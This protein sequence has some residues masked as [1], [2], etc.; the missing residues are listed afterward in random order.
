METI[1]NLDDTRK[2]QIFKKQIISDTEVEGLTT[3]NRLVVLNISIYKKDKDYHFTFQLT[4]LYNFI[5]N[6]IGYQEINIIGIHENEKIEFD[7]FHPIPQEHCILDNEKHKN[8]NQ[9]SYCHPDK[10]KKN[11]K[12]LSIYEDNFNQNEQKDFFKE[13]EEEKKRHEEHIKYKC[14]DK[15]GFS[16]STCES[17]SFEK[18]LYGVWDK[19]CEKNTD[20][21]F[22]KSNR[23]YDNERGGCINGYCEMPINVK[24]RGYQYYDSSEPPFCHNCEREGCFGADCFTCCQEQATNKFKYPKIKSPDFMFLND[25]R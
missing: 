7:R 23:N 8:I 11:T 25:N 19:P 10:L 14:F 3:D 5:Q 9:L 22:F 4:C 24:R 20:C 17:Y 21:P 1:Y 12:T 13:K 18:N 6:V 15:R 16:R 2:Y